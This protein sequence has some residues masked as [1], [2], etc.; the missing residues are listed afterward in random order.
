MG[1][2][3]NHIANEEDGFTNNPVP[4]IQEDVLSLRSENEQLKLEIENLKADKNALAHNVVMLGK[5]IREKED[6]WNYLEK[7]FVTVEK[8]CDVEEKAKCPMFPEFCEGSCKERIDLVALLEK[9]C[10]GGNVC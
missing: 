1:I 3:S 9:A 10:E 7:R 2:W 8:V 4:S 6:L 5:I